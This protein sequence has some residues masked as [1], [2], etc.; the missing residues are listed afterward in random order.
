MTSELKEARQK[1]GYT[2]EKVAEILKIRRQYI[3]D[4]EEENFQDI[5][6]QV[7]VDG[8]MKMYHEFLGIGFHQK[9]DKTIVKPAPP[10]IKE[11]TVN[12]KYVALFAAC[13]LV[14]LVSI[15]SLLKAPSG[16]IVTEKIVEKDILQ[17]TMITNENIIAPYGSN[18]DTIN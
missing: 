17:N 8:Y 2:V 18:E 10:I 15:Y 7:Y 11:S 1:A 16:Q 13:M 14:I 3:I 9:A 5:P 6:G 12:K 4:L